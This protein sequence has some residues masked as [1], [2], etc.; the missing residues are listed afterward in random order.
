VWPEVQACLARR[1]C[2]PAG[3]WPLMVT[4]LLSH[5]FEAKFA[6]ADYLVGHRPGSLILLICFWFK[7]N[8]QLPGHWV[9]N[10]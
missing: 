10:H 6:Q 4:S 5:T 9:E 2:P 1:P 7:L 8:L 3:A